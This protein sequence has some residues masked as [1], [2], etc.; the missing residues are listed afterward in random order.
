MEYIVLY[1]AVGAVVMFMRGYAGPK[2][3]AAS[4]AIVDW[5]RFVFWPFSFPSVVLVFGAA[6]RV[7]YQA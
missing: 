6:V 3:S 1:F 2:A 4:P 5:L 7:G